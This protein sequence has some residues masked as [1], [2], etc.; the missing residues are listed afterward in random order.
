ME[1]KEKRPLDDLHSF[2][3]KAMVFTIRNQ[4]SDRGRERLRGHMFQEKKE[5]TAGFGLDS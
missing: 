5:K 4:A 1:E 2:M 3:K